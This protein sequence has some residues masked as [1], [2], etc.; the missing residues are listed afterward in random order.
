M[1]GIKVLIITLLSTFLGVKYDI[2]DDMKHDLG[3]YVP[4]VVTGTFTFMFIE[5]PTWI[6]SNPY[7]NSIVEYLLKTGVTLFNVFITVTAT[8]F[9]KK[10]LSKYFD[11]N[12][13]ETL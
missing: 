7:F 11:K 10:L 9:F 2:F 5:L 12:D 3:L 8:F 6:T 13:K 4:S 1:T